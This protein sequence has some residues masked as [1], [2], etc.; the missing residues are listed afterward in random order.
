MTL[1]VPRSESNVIKRSLRRSH[2]R[3]QVPIK[4]LY[5]MHLVTKYFK[6]VYKMVRMF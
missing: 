4:V 1:A 3:H 2:T 6:D 5:C